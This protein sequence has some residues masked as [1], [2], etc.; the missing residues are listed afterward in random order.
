MSL[1][2]NF[3][4]LALFVS[5][6]AHAQ[7]NHN[8]DFWYGDW[9]AHD[10][11]TDRIVGEDHIVPI[12]DSLTMLES[13]NDVQGTKG[14]SFTM[15]DRENRVWKQIWTDNTGRTTTLRGTLSGDTMTFL[16]DP[17]LNPKNN[18]VITR[19]RI[20][21]KSENEILQTGEVSVD[22]SATWQSSFGFLYKRKSRS[23]LKGRNFKLEIYGVKILVPDLQ[24]AVDFYVGTLN[25]PVDRLHSDGST[26]VLYSNSLR[27]ILEESKD[28]LV[29]QQ[30]GYGPT[31]L[32][33]R[34]N[35][36]DS[37][38]ARL[39]AR[40]VRF[41][42]D[43]KRTEGVG[44]S[45]QIFDPFGNKISI[46]QLNVGELQPI[47]EPHIYNCGLY[48]ENMTKARE[49]Y[50]SLLGFVERS[51]RYLPDDMPLGYTDG[52]F[53]FMLH[54]TRKDAPFTKSNNMRLVFR[55]N[56]SGL[57]FHEITSLSKSAVLTEGTIRFTDPLGNQIEI[58]ENKY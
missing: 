27:L 55:T 22:N 51:Q 48:V 6:V 24:R 21:K 31:S 38:A 26:I 13:W 35:N 10:L 44:H 2:H 19:M 28:A 5:S 23:T 4:I 58:I 8:F 29:I 41:L 12:L 14:K 50:A 3:L 40:K 1:N 43:S 39:R 37:T 34:V 45:M 9:N 33:L 25:F 16:S 11:T 57:A 32:A 46:M 42:N 20:I 18:L 36:L 52:K 15:Y 53:A 17:R 54:A 47:H 56:N 49:F 30:V 7:V